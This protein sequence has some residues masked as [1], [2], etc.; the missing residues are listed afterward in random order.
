MVCVCS[1][2][3]KQPR[4]GT[5]YCVDSSGW[6]KCDC[7]KSKATLFTFDAHMKNIYTNGNSKI[8][9]Y[10]KSSHYLGVWGNSGGEFCLGGMLVWSVLGNQVDSQCL[11]SGSC[12]SSSNPQV[13]VAN[14]GY[15]WWNAPHK[16]WG[17]ECAINLYNGY[18]YGS[19][20]PSKGP[21][22]LALQST[23]SVQLVVGLDAVG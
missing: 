6:V 14:G 20:T 18:A 3:M 17:M 8:V 2:Y 13:C 16:N 5:Y 9:C 22:D 1:Y 19:Y 11:F 12:P 15:V 4:F 21:H 7:A 23:P 10:K